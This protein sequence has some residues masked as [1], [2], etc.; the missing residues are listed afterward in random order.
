MKDQDSLDGQ[1]TSH[2]A[3]QA[4][5]PPSPPPSPPLHPSQSTI[6]PS[7]PLR[8]HEETLAKIDPRLRKI[9]EHYGTWAR[10]AKKF[11]YT[12]RGIASWARK[13]IPECREGR[14]DE[15]VR[16]IEGKKARKQ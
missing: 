14:V 3:G 13:G 12:E 4:S 5:S 2:Q 15:V 9:Y 16:E 8:A 6:I 10:V 1:N 11:G 7:K